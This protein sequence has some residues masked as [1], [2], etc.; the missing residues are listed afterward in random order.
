MNIEQQR[1][2]DHLDGPAAVLAG[3]G[4]GKT[5]TLI[6]RIEKLSKVVKPERIVMLTFTNAAADEMKYRASKVNEECK[7]VIAC[8]Y[9][10]YC[11]L[12]LRRYGKCIGIEPS[13]EILTGMKYKTLIEYVKSTNEYYESLKDFPSASKLDSIFSAVVNN[14]DLSIEQ[15]T[16]GTKYAKYNTE[17]QNLYTEIKQYGLKN[18]KFNFDVR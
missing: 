3:A 6:G 14:D 4:S 1:V 13:Y 8:T 7:N 18:Q 12:M 9:H 11:G 10:K 17:I 15:L 5:H 2:V 16:Y